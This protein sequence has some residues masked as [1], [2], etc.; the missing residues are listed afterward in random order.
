PPVGLALID[1]GALDFLSAFVREVPYRALYP[2]IGPQRG[3]GRFLRLVGVV[4]G[5]F[6]R[7][8]CTS[9][10]PDYAAGGV[11]DLEADL[12]LRLPL[13]VVIDQRASG[14]IGG[15]ARLAAPLLVRA[16]PFTPHP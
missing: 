5:I 12:V 14:R 10:R 4:R 8:G 13:E 9:E 11:Q 2:R 1:L 3:L 6:R 15:A 16:V 7:L